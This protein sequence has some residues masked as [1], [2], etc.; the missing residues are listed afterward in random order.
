MKLKA[1]KFLLPIS[2]IIS[3]LAF[4]SSAVNAPINTDIKSEEIYHLYPKPH[5]IV[6]AKNSTI[7]RQ[8]FV[9]ES[10]KLDK[11]ANLKLDKI[12]KLK[13]MVKETDLKKEH[14]TIKIVNF[15]KDSDL[16]TKI[17]ND[18]K[19][20]IDIKNFENKDSYSLIVK[21][22]EIVIVG[23]HDDAIYF[24]LSSLYLILEQINGLEV[25]NF[26][27]TDYA[28]LKFRGFI[29]GFYG[30]PWTHEDRKSLM[31]FGG[32]FKM[33]NYTYAPKDDQYHQNKW[34]E[35]YP[36]E[37]LKKLKELVEVG[38]ETKV[39][40]VWTIHPF[41]SHIHRYGSNKN[42]LEKDFQDM[43]D[44]FEQ[45]YS[46]GVRQFGV[47]ADDVGAIPRE[48]I[49]DLMKKLV[50]WGKTKG[51]LKDW[52]FCPVGYNTSWL[53]G[54]KEIHEYDTGFDPEVQIFWTGN[55]VLGAV[56]N[57]TLKKFRTLN[58]PAGSKK[59]RPSLFWLNWPV[60]GQNKKRMIIG[61]AELLKTDI[62]IEDSVGV[63]TNPM[64]D[65]EPSKVGLY[66]TAD[67]TWN[68][69]GFDVDKSWMSTF[70]YLDKQTGSSLQ[71]MAW[72]MSDNKPNGHG[73][74]YD[75]SV[76]IKDNLDV[77]TKNLKDNSPLSKTDK[78]KV[79]HEMDNIISSAADIL[80]NLKNKV[81]YEQMKPF[82]MSL[83]DRAI[84]IKNFIL[85]YELFKE[86]KKINGFKFYSD[87]AQ[88]ATRARTY[89]N[90]IINGTNESEPGYK[91]IRPFND[92]LREIT[93]KFYTDFV[94]E[95]NL[96][97]SESKDKNTL[98]IDFKDDVYKNSDTVK[99]LKKGE[100][101]KLELPNI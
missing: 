52:L 29:E 31:R 9:I 27:I 97:K 28:D 4:L 6:Y 59:G 1:L 54:S 60:N 14:T 91:R 47:L 51:D 61:K 37:E 53:G 50:K 74:T 12:F 39:E 35:K 95:N 10:D 23:K 21:D 11:A 46:I 57:D 32:D 48:T 76:N 101:F 19:S 56:N 16:K 41:M 94:L 55:T 67:Y 30:I 62:D 63:L 38:K 20:L 36:E 15:S 77:L 18:Y 93:S 7:L 17:L 75:E 49:I 58:K 43:I 8:N 68:V 25:K 2:V 90:I 5:K 72:H 24:A 81:L 99:K 26:T 34:F 89:K 87:G 73:S 33:N 45:L 80:T 40:F 3:P 65:A 79:V 96:K 69:K 92:L 100:S 70:R 83:R 64:P 13:N 98:K 71:T 78:E 44:K 86:N 88:F 84:S 85:A 42:K 22:N 82:V 66:A